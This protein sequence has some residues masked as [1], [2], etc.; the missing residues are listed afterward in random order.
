MKISH[1]KVDKV[2]EIAN[3]VELEQLIIQMSQVALTIVAKE[4]YYTSNVSH[5]KKEKTIC[6]CVVQASLG[7]ARVPRIF[8]M[9]WKK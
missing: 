6:Q 1:I 9:L 8:A 3:S 7:Q 2:L 5:H 4:K